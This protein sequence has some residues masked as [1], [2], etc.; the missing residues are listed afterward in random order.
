[1]WWLTLEIPAVETPSILSSRPSWA[2]AFRGGSGHR[3]GVCVCVWMGGH[4]GWVSCGRHRSGE[5]SFL[6]FQSLPQS[7]ILRAEYSME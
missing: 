6:G 5:N 3:A 7:G 4:G 2:P 1:M